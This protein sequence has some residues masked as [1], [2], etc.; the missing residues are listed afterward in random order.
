M[1]IPKEKVIN[2]ALAMK[3]MGIDN[4]HLLEELNE[5]LTKLLQQLTINDLFALAVVTDYFTKF[6]STR[7]D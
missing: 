4:G 1:N 2:C 3:I 7:S 6:K 5:A